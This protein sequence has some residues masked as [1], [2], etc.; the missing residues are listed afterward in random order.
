MEKILLQVTG[1]EAKAACGTTHLAVGVE[2]GI[3][4]AIPAMCVL[5]KEHAQEEDWGF[6]IIDARNAFNGENWTAML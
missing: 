5:R 1:P 3:E 6:L 4:G 2:A